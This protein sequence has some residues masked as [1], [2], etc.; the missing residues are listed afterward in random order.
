MRAIATLGFL[1]SFV[2]A[3]ALLAQSTIT[4]EDVSATVRLSANQDGCDGKP[5]PNCFETIEITANAMADFPILAEGQAEGPDGSFLNGR[6]SATASLD[7]EGLVIELETYGPG[8]ECCWGDD[9]LYFHARA[10]AEIRFNLPVN[11]LVRF[12]KFYSFNYYDPQDMGTANGSNSF[13]ITN[14][15]T[16]DVLED[17][18]WGL[19]EYELAAGDYTVAMESYAWT[20]CDCASTLSQT[21]KISDRPVPSLVVVEEHN[22]YVY[23]N[24][25]GEDTFVDEIVDD[26]LEVDSLEDLPASLSRYFEEDPK[27]GWDIWRGRA[28]SQAFVSPNRFTLWSNTSADSMAWGGGSRDWYAQAYFDFAFTLTERSAVAIDWCMVRE[29]ETDFGQSSGETTTR[30]RLATADMQNILLDVS[31]DT[32]GTDCN[33]NEL[34][35]DPGDYVIWCDATALSQNESG[36]SERSSRTQVDMLFNPLNPADFNGDG[37]VDGADLGSLIAMWG[38]CKGCP[39][40]LNDDGQVDGAD[41]G[42]F[43]SLWTG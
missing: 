14:N 29:E 15:T 18:D 36:T 28:Y 37:H 2:P 17:N 6:S 30:F 24:L 9:F 5:G 7:P 16:G 4:V 22:P 33:L 32:L 3:Q 1:A 38:P 43:I 11:S 41:L 8:E 34:E 27:E 19:S 31:M 25:Y 21:V 26:T 13:T 35:L 12:S 39:Q 10:N 42:L 23:L 40:D 20:S